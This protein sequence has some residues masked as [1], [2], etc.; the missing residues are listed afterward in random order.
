MQH[1]AVRSEVL[2][3]LRL[4]GA[5]A[6]LA[7]SKKAFICQCLCRH[8]RSGSFLVAGRRVRLP[9]TTSSRPHTPSPRNESPTKQL[10]TTDSHH[11]QIEAG[12]KKKR[13]ESTRT[14]C[15]FPPRVAVYTARLRRAQP[16]RMPGAYTR[17]QDADDNKS[18]IV[19]ARQA[20][21][22]V[23]GMRPVVADVPLS[24]GVR[25]V[26]GALTSHE[27]SQTQPNTERESHVDEP[28][29]VSHPYITP[30]PG[31]S[32]RGVAACINP[33]SR[34]LRQAP[35]PEHIFGHAYLQ[36]TG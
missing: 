3:F 36:S 26:S 16:C 7:G 1:R 35:F 13:K 29:G 34:M 2:R 14:Q 5:Q 10:L 28:S 25:D 27:E 23:D 11:I 18:R 4:A 22:R 31:S 6:H 33:I 30:E 20:E 19:A 12:A 24:R 32:T 9:T 17:G 21:V 15:L 8:Q